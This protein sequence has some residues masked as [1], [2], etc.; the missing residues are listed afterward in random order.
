MDVI[1]QWRLGDFSTKLPEQNRYCA[2]GIRACYYFTPTVLPPHPFNNPSGIHSP[3]FTWNP[4]PNL[5]FVMLFNEIMTVGFA[6][7]YVY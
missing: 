3:T 2:A 1:Q 7:V 4:P 5:M 6:V